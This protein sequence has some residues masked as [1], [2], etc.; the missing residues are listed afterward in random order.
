[1]VKKIISKWY[2]ENIDEVFDLCKEVLKSSRYNAGIKEKKSEY[3]LFGRTPIIRV[4]RGNVILKLSKVK[5]KT[6]VEIQMYIK[7]LIDFG[8][9]RRELESFERSLDEALS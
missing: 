9:T 1:M 5:N 6:K 7:C 4:P 8:I 3:T 2:T